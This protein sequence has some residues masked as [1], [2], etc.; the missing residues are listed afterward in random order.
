MRHRI[1]KVLG[2][3]YNGSHKM[4]EHPYFRPIHILSCIFKDRNSLWAKRTGAWKHSWALDLSQGLFSLDRSF[5]FIRCWQEVKKIRGRKRRLPTS[6]GRWIKHSA[7]EVLCFSQ[8]APTS[9]GL[10]SVLGWY[11]LSMNY[12]IST[13]E[14][15]NLGLLR[16]NCLNYISCAR[17]IQTLIT[18][19]T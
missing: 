7:H 1:L 12:V 19:C 18:T 6:Q 3:W 5:S 10:M 9:M 2:S 16:S 11:L 4:F 8:I 14:C 13:E 15:V 17:D